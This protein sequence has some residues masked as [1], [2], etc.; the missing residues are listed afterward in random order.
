MNY[1]IKISISVFIFVFSVFLNSLYLTKGM[2]SSQRASLVFKNKQN[3]KDAL[4]YLIKA[5][6]DV[7]SDYSSKSGSELLKLY[8]ED[9]KE[10]FLKWDGKIIKT[11]KKKLHALRS[12]LLQN[13][14][15]DEQKILYAVSKI[16]PAEFKFD[17]GVYQYGGIYF[18]SCGALIKACSVLGICKLGDSSFYME[19]HE[20]AALLYSAGKFTGVL[21]AAF[22]AVILFFIGTD[23]FSFKAGLFSALFAATLPSIAFE[24]HALKPYAFFLPFWGLCVYYSLKSIKFKEKFNRFYFLSGLYAGLAGGSMLLASFC[25]F[26]FLTAYFFY[27][28]ENKINLKVFLLG[29]FAFISGFFLANPYYIFSF[30]NAFGEIVYVKGAHNLVFSLSHMIRFALFELNKILSW[31]VYLLFAGAVILGFKEKNKF[32][33][34]SSSPFFFYFIYTSNA[35]WDFPHYSMPLAAAALPAAGFFAERMISYSKKAYLILSFA[36]LFNL[37]NTLYDRKIFLENEENLNK[38]GKWITENIPK[39]AKVAFDTYPYFGFKSYPPFPLP[40][41]RIKEKN[42]GDYYVL[43]DINQYYGCMDLSYRDGMS[44]SADFDKKYVLI[45]DFYRKKTFW[46]KIYPNHR[47]VLFEQRIAVYKKK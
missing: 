30:K 5:R 37:G 47:Y 41:Y 27:A 19:N 11:E 25:V 32:L 8:K 6:E 38:A 2:P 44:E 3:L 20:Q 12:V 9:S 24:A 43:N 17:P 31:P 26:S 35:H 18:Y 10:A 22:F 15:P 29:P 1:K 40:D 34:V 14:F 39:G 42:D 23:F 16:K 33:I 28:K 7:Y 21:S 4:P 45:A 13:R 36:V 46:D